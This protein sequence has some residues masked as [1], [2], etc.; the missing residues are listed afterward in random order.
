MAGLDET[1]REVF[2]D[3][4]MPTWCFGRLC[5]ILR[6]VCKEDRR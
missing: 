1:H 2:P 3:S 4:D 5:R 6:K